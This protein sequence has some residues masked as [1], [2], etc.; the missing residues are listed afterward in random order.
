LSGASS[1]NPLTRRPIAVS[2]LQAR[3]PEELATGA[4][5]MDAI[6]CSMLSEKIREGNIVAII[7]YMKNRLGWTDRMETHRS[8]TV[9]VNV[10]I[11]GDELT[12]HLEAHNLPTSLFGIDKPVL[13]AEPR[14]IE[15]N[16]SSEPDDDGGSAL[17]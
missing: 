10:K 7:W 4:A 3:F 6:C 8:G 15:G 5:K 9:D 2:T 11:S 16:G 1:L 12:K 17:H 14:L 13:D